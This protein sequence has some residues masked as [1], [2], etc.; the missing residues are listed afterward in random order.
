MR[1]SRCFNSKYPQLQLLHPFLHF[2]DTT[3][4]LA[5]LIPLYLCL[6]SQFIL[7]PKNYVISIIP[8]SLVHISS[9]RIP[10]DALSV[11]IKTKR[12]KITSIPISLCTFHWLPF[13]CC[14]SKLLKGLSSPLLYFLN[15]YTL[16]NTSQFCL[17][18]IIPLNNSI[19]VPVTP[20]I[21]RFKSSFFFFFF[22]SF[23]SFYLFQGFSHSIWSFFQA[24]GP[25]GT[26]AAGLRQSHSNAI[27][28]WICNY[29]TAHSN[30]GSLTH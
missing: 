15:S 10:L 13:L 22:F 17:G 20:H 28:S 2:L 8:F 14:T 25:I 11:F 27:S 9:Y 6:N 19:L 24:R 3:E 21:H 1:T 16:P 30:A 4:D 12:S 26:V 7:S 29:T 18:S 23:W 5:L